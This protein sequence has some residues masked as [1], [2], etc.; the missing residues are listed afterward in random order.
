MGITEDY[1]KEEAA[2]IKAMMAE[3]YTPD[4]AIEA[5]MKE[6]RERMKALRAEEQ[7]R[8]K[9]LRESLPGLPEITE[10]GKV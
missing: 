8:M 5:M 3:Y 9:A 2:R 1:M 4:P 10:G 7:E 6:E